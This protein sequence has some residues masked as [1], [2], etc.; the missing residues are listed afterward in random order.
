[1]K[2]LKPT[3][4]IIVTL[5]I[6]NI[7]AQEW[8]D[9]F[10][11]PGEKNFYEIQNSFNKEWKN[12]S[13]ERGKGFKQFKRWEWYWE[14]RVHKDGSF[15]E[16][17]I[18]QKELEKYIKNHKSSSSDRE[19]LDVNWKSEG[20]SNSPGGYAG[21]GR[22]GAIGF[23]PTD[24]NI[25]YAGA[26]GGGLWISQDGGSTWETTT[27]QLL[28]LGISGIVVD[29]SNPN[30]V[31]IATGDADGRDNNSVGVLKSL[32]GGYTWNITGLNWGIS[33]FNY[34]RRLIQDKSDP[35]RLLAATSE[36]LLVTTDG[37]DTWETKNNG[38]YVD[39]EAKPD[40]LDNTYYACDYTDIYVSNDK[41]ETWQATH[42][43]IGAGRTAIATTAGNDS[44][45]YALCS[46][47][48]SG[49]L[50]LFRSVDNG[51]SFETMSDAP[52]ILGWSAQGTDTDGQGWYD[53]IVEAD[54]N[55]PNTVFVGGINTWKSTDGG[56]TWNIASHWSYAE[57]AQTV[58]ADKHVFEWQGDVLWEGNDGG[59]Y[60]TTD[61]GVFWDH[62]SNGMVI[63][64]MYRLGASQTDARVICGLQDNGTKLK[65]NDNSWD[66]VGG[67]DGMECAINPVNSNIMYNEVYYGSIR[68]SKNGGNSWNSITPSG[69]SGAWVTPYD[70]APSDPSHLYI[71]YDDVYKSTDH[72]D[73][74]EIIS[75]NIAGGSNLRS[76]KV[77]PSNSN[78]IYTSTSWG[79][80]RTKDGG[81]NWSSIATPN[82]GANMIA[83][84]SLDSNLV[85]IVSSNYDEGEKVYQSIDAGDTWTNIS[86][87][88]PNIPT[89]CILSEVGDKN[90][91]YVGM[92][93]GVF[94]K[95]DSMDDW[96]LY[97]VG[98][99]NVEIT[100]LE[101]NYDEE[102]LYAS[103][104]GRGLWKSKM[105]DST[106]SCFRINEIELT[107]FEDNGASFEWNI[108]ETEPGNG[109]E[110]MLNT[111]GLNPSSGEYVAD[112]FIDIMDLESGT[113]YYFFVRKVCDDGVSKWA[114]YGPISV[115]SK[116][117]DIIY[118][119][120]GVE[121]DYSDGENM[122]TVICP[123]NTGEKVTFDFKAFGIEEDYDALYVY[124]GNTI[125]ATIIH[126]GRNATG[127]GF[128]AG[129]YFGEVI[130]G[131][132]TS[133]DSTGC[134]T[135]HFLS[136]SYVTSIGWEIETICD[137]DC[138]I[139]NYDVAL[140][141]CNEG[142]FRV[143]HLIEF[144]S[145]TCYYNDWTLTMN[146]DSFDVVREGLNYYSNEVSSP[147]SLL[148]FEF[149]S[150]GG[151]ED[152][153]TTTV[154][155]PCFGESLPCAFLSF[156][157]VMDSIYC[158]DKDSMLVMFD[159]EV[160]SPGSMGYQISVNGVDSEVFNYPDTAAFLVA[161]NCSFD[162]NLIIN[163]IEFSDCEQLVQMNVCC[164]VQDSCVVID[165]SLIVGKEDDKIALSLY[166]RTE[167]N[168]SPNYDVWVNDIHLGEVDIVN[169][170]LD[171]PLFTS[172][173]DSLDIKVCNIGYAEVCVNYK[174]PNPL[175]SSNLNIID[176]QLSILISSEKK[177]TITKKDLIESNISIYNVEGKLMYEVQSPSN[178]KI[179]Q[180]DANNWITGIYMFRIDSKHIIN[181]QKI[182]ID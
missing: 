120:G 173:E 172:D 126:S 35:N 88:L 161:S 116:C 109:Y 38:N 71:G 166:L 113:D 182:Y 144:E 155:N 32:D 122:I 124:D 13:Y 20:P 86:G 100:E 19:G 179:I 145:D 140:D 36:G 67:G 4:T 72:G 114:K 51:N 84:H 94:Y 66:D 37:G 136:D 92:D 87:S 74:W 42:S 160:E 103:T 162:Y 10:T 154:V 104:Y 56:V 9:K 7:N 174:V 96:E 12:K 127:A 102:Y 76:I 17:G 152:C 169:D 5:L 107:S 128:P 95:N 99:P 129:G 26:G 49:F 119:S 39:L 15:P 14:T 27:D 98:L 139:K 97:G 8:V 177:I 130:P 61:G 106:T 89:N 78:Y 143:Q 59:V 80:W 146:G 11:K 105:I 70:L 73:S 151:A 43:F 138:T 60:K 63:S 6:S 25:I 33:D 48:Q 85:W 170:T 3:I 44:Y 178:E 23:H 58:H 31:Y 75:E 101:I 118:D 29:Y 55:N 148:S 176:D 121:N 83:V 62:K 180:I 52:N 171:F 50:G 163:D 65:R 123:R 156:T 90:G 131:P 112:N 117:G 137:L 181:S 22:I 64:Q 167:N 91:L 16:P 53:L 93:V 165:T 153:F 157:P 46:N 30:I 28:S 79:M 142:S 110:W 141:D 2:F 168:C 68:R 164:P 147:D 111:T 40:G 108:S 41:G 149:C 125:D 77:A 150:E 134:L 133:T 175:L 57:G 54:P 69:A 132:F 45:V 159:Y 34:I 21:I 158:G 82:G 47:N 1:M 115:P 135:L 18:A 81:E 24:E